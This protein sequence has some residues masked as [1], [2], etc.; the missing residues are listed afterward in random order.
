MSLGP[1]GGPQPLPHPNR[2]ST[3]TVLAPPNPMSNLL[4][5]SKPLHFSKWSRKIIEIALANNQLISIY[6][7]NIPQRWMPI[8]I[9]LFMN[10]YTKVMDVFPQKRSRTGKRYAFVRFK[11]GIH[12]PPVLARINSTQVDGTFLYSLVAKSRVRAKLDPPLCPTTQPHRPATAAFPPRGIIKSFAEVVMPRRTEQQPYVSVVN[13]E[14]VFVSKDGAPEWLGNCALGVLRRSMPI[15]CLLDLFP[16]DESSVTDVIPLG[17]VSFLFKFQSPEDMNATIQN[18]PALFTQLFEVF[19]AWQ[20]ADVAFNR[21]CWILIRGVPPHLWSKIFS[22]VLV[23]DFGSMVD[24]SNESRS[25]YRFDIS[26]VLILTTSNL[27]INKTLSA[28]A[29]DNQYVIGITESQFDPLTR[30]GLRR[31]QFIHPPPVQVTLKAMGLSKTKKTRYLNGNA[32]VGS[33][34][35]SKLPETDSNICRINQRVLADASSSSNSNSEASVLPPNKIRCVDWL[36]NFTAISPSSAVVCGI[37]GPSAVD[38]RVEM[39]RELISLK[40]D[41]PAPWLALRDFNEV[42]NSADKKVAISF[43]EVQLR[44]WNS[45]KDCLL[46]NLPWKTDCSLGVI[47]LRQAES[48]GFLLKENGISC[49]LIC[50]LSPVVRWV[51][52]TA[53][54]CCTRM[55][56]NRA[57]DHSGLYQLGQFSSLMPQFDYSKASIQWRDACLSGSVSSRTRVDLFEGSKIFIGDG[58]RALFWLDNWLGHGTLKTLFP[59]LFSVSLCKSF[60]VAQAL[61]PEN[62]LP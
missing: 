25:L 26:K 59:R 12:L 17:G 11:S 40:Q 43:G 6:V 4:D 9:H 46:S 16:I 32:S 50:K 60:T 35:D 22:Q 24:W 20:D 54:S 8:D 13:K 57:N 28:M 27:F 15:K 23:S 10:R 14:P 21:L 7:E 51:P 38:A 37:F 53:L 31:R 52:I 41:L 55:L 5:T 36:T 62:N 48:T 19:R 58:N 39:F 18:K 42:L 29:G 45:C 47:P 2:N 34:S 56:Q 1:P 44:L 61:R 49:S 33:I 3:L 30:T